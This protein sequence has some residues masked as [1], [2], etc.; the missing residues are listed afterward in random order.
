MRDTTGQTLT[1]HRYLT[2]M[3]CAT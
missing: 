2:N 3:E 1:L